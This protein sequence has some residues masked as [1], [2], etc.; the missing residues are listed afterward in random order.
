MINDWD[1]YFMSMAYFVAMKS[2]DDSTKIGAIVVGPDREIRSTGF[3]DLPR[4]LDHAEPT[5]HERPEKYLWYEHAE[6]NAIYNASRMGIST[7][8][9]VLYTQGIPCSDCARGIIQS[10]ISEVVVD[11]HWM[12]M[13]GW[14]KW[15]DLA[16]R[17]QIMFTEAKVNLKFFQGN[18][19]SNIKGFRDGGEFELS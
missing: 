16:K 9:C 4:H 3:N 11:S 10:G 14:E 18:C 13:P 15:I 19:I 1:E 12:N 5:R 6:R 8:G 7:K 17:S 2:K